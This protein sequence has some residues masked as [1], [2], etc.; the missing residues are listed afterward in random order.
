MVLHSARAMC[1]VGS[2]LDL[3][4]RPK[5]CARDGEN[6]IVLSKV[7]AYIIRTCIYVGVGD[8]LL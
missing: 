1:E 2:L 8:A 5:K 3:D 6:A 4:G 7:Y